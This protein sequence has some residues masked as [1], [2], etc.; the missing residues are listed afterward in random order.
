MEVLKYN[1]QQIDTIGFAKDIGDNVGLL[2]GLFSVYLPVWCILLVGATQNFLGY[3]GLW[4]VARGHIAEP[5]FWL[6]WVMMWLGVNG[7]TFFITAGLVT[8]VRN[9]P[10]SR[11]V[12]VGLLKGVV[13]LSGAIYAQ[14]YTAL[15]SPQQTE[16]LL[17]AAVGPAL[18][19][20]IVLPFLTPIAVSEGESIDR[21]AEKREK[22]SFKFL[23]VVFIALALYLMLSNVINSVWPLSKAAASAVA[24]VM[25][26]LLATPLLVP[27][28]HSQQ[29]AAEPT[30]LH[31]SLLASNPGANGD[32]GSRGVHTFGS[33]AGKEDQG[34]HRETEDS[35]PSGG[36]GNGAAASNPGAGN[37]TGSKT[38]PEGR[39][40]PESS[41]LSRSVAHGDEEEHSRRR[42]R[43]SGFQYSLEGHVLETEQVAF[44]ATDPDVEVPFLLDDDDV[45]SSISASPSLDNLE[46]LYLSQSQSQS[47]SS[48]RV[49]AEDEGQGPIGLSGER[50]Q[51]NGVV[52]PGTAARAEADSRLAGSSRL[53]AKARTD[54]TR[55]Q[56]RRRRRAVRPR[57]GEN[58]TLF[59][60]LVKADYWLLFFSVLCGASTGLTAVNNLAQMGQAQGFK[61]MEIPVAL[62]S[63]WNFMG[64][65]G[66]GFV[67]EYLVRKR[68][69]PRPVVTGVAQALM[70][71]GHLLFAFAVPGSIYMGSL[72]VGSGYGTTLTMMPAIASE[73]FGLK[74]FGLFY[75]SFTCGVPVGTYL[76][77]SLL[78]GYVYDREA[79]KE[80]RAGGGGGA[81]TIGLA[82][83]SA[84]GPGDVSRTGFGLLQETGVWLSAQSPSAEL[85]LIRRHSTA[86]VSQ[87][88]ELSQSR[89]ASRRLLQRLQTDVGEKRLVGLGKSHGEHGSSSILNVITPWVRKHSAP[90]AT[91]HGAHCFK[92]TFL[93][94]AFV[95]ALGVLANVILSFRTRQVYD[96][97]Y[98]NPKS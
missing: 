91:C 16:F 42:A 46:T 65:V 35:V 68:N 90:T 62:V 45:S 79:E 44:A 2:A 85:G 84:G 23:F 73:L 22:R 56:K 26:L 36:V 69:L 59:E 9:F 98:G 37:A 43:G 71:V 30:A 53:A 55:L 31:A 93:V 78:A 58:F 14:L 27:I 51:H 41:G 3:G 24:L 75:N 74:N 60:G 50:V 6:V 64:R 40:V 57:R 94:M 77:S 87:P 17:L 97:L 67:S 39:A 15:F 52:A 47:Q 70:V 48:L 66:G 33:S 28:Y 5:P 49:I 86:N 76:F 34:V 82:G 38:V 89:P 95:S 83:S 25:L 81:P 20:L 88:L 92:L 96:R 12:V 54:E 63:I 4:L 11:G 18:V 1:Q 19:A 32:S 29:A 7:A 61:D 8:S 80:R 72:I 10:V 21:A 13:G